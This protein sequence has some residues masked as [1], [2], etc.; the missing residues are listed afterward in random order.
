M[1]RSGN[2]YLFYAAIVGAGIFAQSWW[3]FRHVG[4]AWYITYLII[5][6]VVG[7]L[8]CIYIEELFQRLWGK[9]LFERKWIGLLIYLLITGGLVGLGYV[10]LILP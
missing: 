1:K 9:S 8:L 6:T 4:W 5:G 2:H 10:L 3:Y 7:T